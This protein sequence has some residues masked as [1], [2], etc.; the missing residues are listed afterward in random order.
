MRMT[1][2]SRSVGQQVVHFIMNSLKQA[3]VLYITVKTYYKANIS[4]VFMSLVGW[5]VT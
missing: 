3:G 2:K 1:L 4:H 5:H